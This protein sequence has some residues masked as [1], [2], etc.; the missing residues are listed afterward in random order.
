[1]LNNLT[2][3][4]ER[5][6]DVRI[7][8]TLLLSLIIT[9]IVVCIGIYAVSV[10]TDRIEYAAERKLM[11]DLA[12]GEQIIDLSYPGPWQLVNGHQSSRGSTPHGSQ[13]PSSV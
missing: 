6:A 3:N 1:M 5:K 11:S 12:L 8:I 2:E 10:F 13:P 4:K 9:T 7:R